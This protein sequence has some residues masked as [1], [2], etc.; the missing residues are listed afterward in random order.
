M[1]F[2]GGDELAEALVRLD[3]LNTQLGTRRNTYLLLEA[4]RKHFEANLVRA[5]LGKSS[6]EKK[7]NAEA[8][9]EWLSFHRTLARAESEYEF[10]KLQMSILEKDWQSKYLRSKLDGELIKKQ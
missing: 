5:A 3:A 2:S 10:L 9:V 1:K 7:I 8:T 6:V 4:E